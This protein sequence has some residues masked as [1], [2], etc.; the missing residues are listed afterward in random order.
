MKARDVSPLRILVVDDYPDTRRSLRL[1]LTSWGHEA[2]EATDGADAL[3]VAEGFRPDVVLLDLALPG[4]DG[5]EVA[6]SLRELL[7]PLPPL[8]V[9]LTGHTGAREV[10]AAVEAGFDHFFAKPCDPGQIDFLLRACARSRP[11]LGLTSVS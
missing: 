6:R 1:L 10:G 5:Y 9:A 3:R 11:V 8:L 7:R 2:R 4:A